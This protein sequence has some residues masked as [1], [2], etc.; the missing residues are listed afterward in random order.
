M[1]S[2]TENEKTYWMPEL[3][4]ESTMEY[5]KLQSEKIYLT[6]ENKERRHP[7]WTYADNN[8]YVDDEY[9]FQNEGWKLVVDDKPKINDNDLKRLIKNPINKWEEIDEKTIKVTYTLENFTQLEIGEFLNKKWD[10]LRD[11][12]NLL[13]SRTDWIFIRA[14]EQDLTVSEEVITYRQSLRDFPK[15][16]LNILEFDVTDN[17]LFPT[18][19]STFF[20]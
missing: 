14:N 17:N 6:K 4:P 10:R 16:I 18:K 3:L 8:A 2:I 1:S 19:P 12:R 9:L 7:G 20:N 13:L 5:H 15:T 11:V